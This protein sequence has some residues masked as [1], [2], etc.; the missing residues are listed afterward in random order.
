[1]AKITLDTI[2]SSHAST[3]LFNTNYSAIQTELNDKVLY[4]VNPIGEAN[5]MENDLD[6]NSNDIL[7]AGAIDAISLQLDGTFL[8]PLANAETL[9]YLDTEFTTA[10]GDTVFAVVYTV[11]FLDVFYNGSLLADA[12]YTATDG[13]TVTLVEAVLSDSD[14]I[15]FRAYSSFAVAN[16]LTIA[17]NLSDVNSASTSRTNLGLGTAAVADVQSSPTDATANKVLTTGAG[18]LLVTTDSDATDL[19]GL[20]GT[21]TKRFGSGTLNIPDFLFGTVQHIQRDSLDATQ[22]ASQVAGIAAAIRSKTNGTWSAWQPVYTGAN[23]QP[24]TNFGIGVVQRMMNR[25]TVT[26]VDGQEFSGSGLRS[27]YRSST[28]TVTDLATPPT[29]TWKNVTGGS[30][31]NNTEGT[32]V[33]L[34]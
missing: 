9:T 23:Y 34:S 22:F 14:V 13:S 21:Q 32:F 1:M 30:V 33:R 31:P 25:T 24:E 18:G 29:S 8:T 11:G 6:M 27:F 15:T 5:Q 4:R 7:N 17:N 2:T 19:N 10:D 28:G 20:N 16:A 3:S 12:D 26:V